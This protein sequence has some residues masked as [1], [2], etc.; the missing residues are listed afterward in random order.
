M[1]YFLTKHLIKH[2]LQRPVNAIVIGQRQKNGPIRDD[3]IKVLFHILVRYHTLHR[4]GL[5]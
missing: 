1:R 2:I 4:A 3:L 5:E